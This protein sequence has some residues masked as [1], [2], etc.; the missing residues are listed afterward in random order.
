M[1]KPFDVTLKSLLEDAPEDWPRLAGVAN[2]RVTVIDAD[3]ATISG[4]A[5]K[6][7]RLEGPPPWIMHFEFQSG[8]DASLPARTNLYSTALEYRHQL[9]VQSVVVLLSPRAHLSTITGTLESTLPRATGPYRVFRYQLIRVWELPVESLLEGGL[10]QLALA[11][12][13]AVREADL[14]DVIQAM[15]QRTARVHDRARLGRWWTAV[16]VLMGLRYDQQLVNQLL[17]GVIGME[18]SVTYQAIVAKGEAKGARQELRKVLLSQGTERFGA[19][20][21][22]WAATALAQMEDLEQ[23]EALATKLLRVESWDELL[24]QPRKSPRRK[25]GGA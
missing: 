6:V 10:G 22:P 19:P 16:S 5:D 1:A 15:K 14:S 24:P 23:L 21:P 4:A 8:P 25:K 9:P 2:P 13:S 7:L 17:E 18:E 3:I 20:A 11:P 12:I